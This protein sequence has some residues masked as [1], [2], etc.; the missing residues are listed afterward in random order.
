[1][2]CSETDGPSQEPQPA[3]ARE[4]APLAARIGSVVFG[5]FWLGGVGTMFSFIAAQLWQEIRKPLFYEPV[6][7]VVAG[8][9]APETKTDEFGDDES[10]PGVIDYRYKVA[11]NDYTDKH[12]QGRQFA[13]E[14]SR[15]LAGAFR[16]GDKLEAW[17]D[18]DDPSESTLEPIA[19]PQ[20]LGFLIFIM[21]FVAVG[22]G[23]S[24][25]A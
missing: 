16:K 18:P 13:N 25:S 23:M 6:P 7:A 3:I 19:Q 21:P 24:S 12:R 5:L 10:T 11:G 9:A 20:L 15:K 17:Y 1:M 2:D 14:Y 8:Y 4:A 22:A